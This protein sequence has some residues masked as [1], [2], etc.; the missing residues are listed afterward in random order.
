MSTVVLR[1]QGS[2]YKVAK[3]PFESDDHAYDRA[4]YIVTKTN[5]DTM[6]WDERVSMSHMWAYNKYYG[7]NF[8]I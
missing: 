6:S 1:Y 4:W 7:M 5:P 2:I 3:S 8:N